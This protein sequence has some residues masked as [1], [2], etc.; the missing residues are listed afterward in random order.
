RADVRWSAARR[1]STRK[2]VSSPVA[3][4][5][6]ARAARSWASAASA[7]QTALC[8]SAFRA[9]SCA[10][11]R[12]WLGPT[13]GLPPPEISRRRWRISASRSPASRARSLAIMPR[14]SVTSIGV[15]SSPI[16]SRIR[17]AR[18][19]FTARR[20]RGRSHGRVLHE[21]YRAADLA[22]GRE[23]GGPH[24]A[25]DRLPTP[26]DGLELDLPVHRTTG[27]DVPDRLPQLGDRQ[28][29]VQ[30]QEVLAL[31]LVGSQSPEILG[32]LV[33][34]AHQQLPVHDHDPR[35]EARQDRLEIAVDVAE[36]LAALPELLV[37]RVHLLV[38]RLELLVHGLELLVGGLQLLVGGLEL[39]DRR[40][41]LL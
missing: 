24:A 26:V 35:P 25:H 11:R 39:L 20:W 33:P 28:P 5:S 9:C 38:R 1:R 19:P 13:C 16:G 34:D 2:P 29:D 41:Q 4:S 3:A 23:R 30:V 10:S 27:E 6:W 22:V 14:S 37:D 32:P 12:W 21:Q 15:L 31:D 8:S 40:L 17:R 7:K 36:L 18:A